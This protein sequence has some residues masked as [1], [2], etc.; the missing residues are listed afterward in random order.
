MTVSHSVCKRVSFECLKNGNIKRHT[1]CHT[2]K[3]FG[4]FIGLHIRWLFVHVTLFSFHAVTTATDVLVWR[5]VSRVSIYM[6]LFISTDINEWDPFHWFTVCYP[7]IHPSIHH[8]SIANTIRSLICVYVR[9][10]HIVEIVNLVE[11]VERHSIYVIL[12]ICSLC[13]HTLC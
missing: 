8:P 9:I 2:L 1:E 4:S 12:H 5:G 6:L 11:R 7:A 3:W 10:V 13:A